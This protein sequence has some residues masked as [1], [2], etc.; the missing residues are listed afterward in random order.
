M[1]TS[2]HSSMQLSENSDYSKNSRREKRALET[3]ASAMDSPKVTLTTCSRR[4]DPHLLE[5]HHPWTIQGKYT[6]IQTNFENRIYSLAI[7]CPPEYPS[8]PPTLQFITKI[9]I[10]SVNQ[11]NGKV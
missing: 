1:A 3:E 8:K 6:C 4:Y 7:E 11:N 9:N 10:P 2:N 5:W